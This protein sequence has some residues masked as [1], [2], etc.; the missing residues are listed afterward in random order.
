MEPTWH[1]NCV[2][3]S[4]SQRHDRNKISVTPSARNANRKRENLF[5]LF[6]ALFSCHHSAPLSYGRK[7]H[8]SHAIQS[9]IRSLLCHLFN[10][11]PDTD[12]A[13]SRPLL[14]VSERVFRLHYRC[15]YKVTKQLPLYDIS[16]RRNTQSDFVIGRHHPWRLSTTTSSREESLRVVQGLH[17]WLCRITTTIKCRPKISFSC[18]FIVFFSPPPF[19]FFADVEQFWWRRRHF[20]AGDNNIETLH[21]IKISRNL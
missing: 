15:I 14:L 10:Q 1:E 12:W 8:P 5:R 17:V 6:F 11:F 16:V 4:K 13:T 20:L 7:R 21:S 9:S 3:V 18:H 2:A 19:K